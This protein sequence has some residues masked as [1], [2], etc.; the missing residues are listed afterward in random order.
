MLRIEIGIQNSVV[1]N[2]HSE[3]DKNGTENTHNRR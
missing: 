2:Q 3:K 1:S